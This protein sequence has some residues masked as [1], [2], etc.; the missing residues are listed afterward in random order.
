MVL[1]GAVLELSWCYLGSLG[2]LLGLSWGSLGALLGAMG[3]P[4]ALLRRSG[5]FPTGPP[6]VLQRPPLL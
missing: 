1:F 6:R 4:G 2:A 3:R 5:A